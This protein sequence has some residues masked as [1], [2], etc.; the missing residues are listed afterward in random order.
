MVAN[1]FDS[2]GNFRQRNGS[3][4]QPRVEGG[5]DAARDGFYNLARDAVHRLPP[6][7]PQAGCG[8]TEG[9]TGQG[10]RDV[11]DHSICKSFERMSDNFTVQNEN[12]RDCCIFEN[13]KI[14]LNLETRV[15]LSYSQFTNKIFSTNVSKLNGLRY[16]NF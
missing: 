16:S 15:Y 4:K 11:H 2:S 5:S 14:T 7:C 1:L 6:P 10:Q 9:P 8:E 12:F 3:F 13:S